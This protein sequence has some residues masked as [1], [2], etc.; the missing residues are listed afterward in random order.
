VIVSAMTTTHSYGQSPEPNLRDP[1]NQYCQHL[2][3]I[4]NKQGL[5][6]AIA[7]KKN[8]ILK[9]VIFFDGHKGVKS[10]IMKI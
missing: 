5:G 1:N 7:Y 9:N 6:L 8:S 10:Y 2:A 4:T 3:M